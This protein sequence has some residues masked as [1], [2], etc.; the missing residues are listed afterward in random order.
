MPR[1]PQVQPTLV[2]VAKT[3]TKLD[4]SWNLITDDIDKGLL[5]ISGY[6]LEGNANS[7]FTSTTILNVTLVSSA[8]SYSFLRSS[9]TYTANTNY[10]FRVYGVNAAG[11]G[12]SASMTAV[13]T[14][15]VP[16]K[17]ATPTVSTIN[18]LNIVINWVQ[19]TTLADIGYESI[20]N[21]YI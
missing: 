19:L 11:F 12:A 6:Q 21:Y 18:P 20:T 15:T 2:L 8:T 13:L 9:F 3:M 10:Y 1:V 4:F 5:S 16:I 17:M 7:L 14:P